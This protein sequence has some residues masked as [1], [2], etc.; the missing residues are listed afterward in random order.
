ML[1]VL[2]RAKVQEVR[3]APAQYCTRG[4]LSAPSAQVQYMGCMKFRRLNGADHHERGFLFTSQPEYPA[5]VQPTEKPMIASITNVKAAG[6]A[7]GVVLT[8]L[9][10]APSFAA[11]HQE[12]PSKAETIKIIG[13]VEKPREWTPDQIK[14]E[15]ATEI[16]TV[17]YTLKGNKGEAQCLP[18]ITLVQAAKL[19]INPK[20]K[21]HE[22][23][24]AVV[25]KGR[26]GYAA[27]FS[28]GELLPQIGNR[29]VW[30]ALDRSG[31]LLP[32]SAAPAEVI[33]VD[34]EKPS[35]WVHAVSS[36]SVIDGVQAAEIK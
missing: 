2:G 35:R 22:L 7:V 1:V 32:D 27:C 15:F 11:A 17:P 6:V 26:D 23:A 19:K 36:I 18:L 21:N 10:W 9:L 34:D 14:T 30:L 33:S 13:A 29:A 24:F 20:Q 31:K 3:G 8:A 5:H 16:K 25:V 12:Q 28:Y 4:E